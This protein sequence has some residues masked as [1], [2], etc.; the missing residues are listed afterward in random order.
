M[1]KCLLS[2]LFVLP[3]FSF[4][5]VEFTK[6]A[7]WEE[8][9][10]NAASSGKFIFIDAYTDWCGWC[11]VMDNK[12]FSQ[13]SVSQIMNENFVNYKIEMEKE[14]LGQLLAMKYGVRSFPSFIILN[15][16][17]ELHR[18]L[19]GYSPPEEWIKSLKST[20]NNET[21]NRKE[22][23]SELNIEWPSMYTQYFGYKVEKRSYPSPSEMDMYFSEEHSLNEVYFRM[24]MAFISGMSDY[25]GNDLLQRQKEMIALFGKDL[26]EEW[27]GKWLKRNLSSSKLKEMTFDQLEMELQRYEEHYSDDAETRIFT[28]LNFYMINENYTETVSWVNENLTVLG[29]GTLNSVSWTLYEKCEDLELLKTANSWMERVVQSEPT[30]AYLDT[31]AA[32]LYKS[33]NNKKAD[34]AAQKAIQIGKEEGED[35]S[36]TEALLKTIRSAK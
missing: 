17:G 22:I 15:K 8:I 5:Q 4:A 9:T 3:L 7:S 1:K 11:K 21:P 29:N 20:L 2:I 32:L 28:V 33:K 24:S 34:I 26:A 19:T 10:N 13:T 27:M 16:K 30:Y 23:K 12:T 14:E 35:V 31:Q 25:K 6:N 36:A 18:I